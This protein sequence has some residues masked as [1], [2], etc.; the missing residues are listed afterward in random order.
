M[1]LSQGVDGAVKTIYSPP[2]LLIEHNV[3]SKGFIVKSKHVVR[4][5]R[6][7]KGLVAFVRAAA[8]KSF[9]GCPSALHLS[10]TASYRQLD[11]NE[12]QVHPGEGSA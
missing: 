2:P 8:M 1:S 12:V 6:P 11:R 9:G 4:T 7:M 5:T 3:S 10:L